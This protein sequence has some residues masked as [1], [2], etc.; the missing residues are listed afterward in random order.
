MVLKKQLH[1]IYNQFFHFRH[2]IYT[3]LA[4]YFPLVPPHR[5]VFVLTNQCNLN[6]KNCFQDRE[7]KRNLLSKEEWIGLSDTIPRS[8]RVTITGG[9]PLLFQGFKEVFKSIASSH[10]CN[11]ITNGVLLTEEL[12]D[13]LLSFSKFRVLAIS[14]DDLKSHI[15]NIRGLGHKQW[16]DL[17]RILKYFI[18]RRDKTNSS[19]A[20][21]IKTLVLDENADRLFDIHKYCMEQLKADQHTFQFLKGTPLQHS[22]KIY[23]IKQIFS[24]YQASIY[25]KF[26]LIINELNKIKEYNVLY[27]KTAFLHPIVADLNTGK[28][29]K[30]ISFM[31]KGVFNKQLF[32]PCKFPWSSLHVNY[33]GQILPCLSVAVGNIKENSI[34]QILK[35]KIYKGFLS[36]IRKN[37]LV[38]ACNGCGWLRPVKAKY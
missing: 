6:C 2:E 17:E 5:F 10:Q 8:S 13:L 34:S 21:E 7:L 38:G 22:D 23:D 12:V 25:K 19:C 33:D 29:L 1:K 18:V 15:D 27:H 9:E 3:K 11:L 24:D 35:G 20:L 31:N 28:P 37:G 4:Y 26:D 30:D 16:E 32:R 36:V 14:I